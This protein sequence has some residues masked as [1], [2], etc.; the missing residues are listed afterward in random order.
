MAGLILW[1]LLSA[2]SAK[3]EAVRDKGRPALTTGLGQRQNSPKTHPKKIFKFITG[4]S[5]TS[6]TGARLNSKEGAMVEG[7]TDPIGITHSHRQEMPNNFQK[8]RK[9]QWH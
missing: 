5:I 8:R 7:L 3:T 1:R 2:F 4:R 6:V 9:P